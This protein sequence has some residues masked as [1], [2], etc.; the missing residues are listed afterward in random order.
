MLAPAAIS[1]KHS[2][3][4]PSFKPAFLPSKCSVGYSETTAQHHWL[5][6]KFANNIRDRESLTGMVFDARHRQL[7]CPWVDGLTSHRYGVARAMGRS[8]GIPITMGMELNGDDHSLPS[9]IRIMTIP[10]S[11]SARDDPNTHI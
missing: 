7:N 10:A 9:I 6:L 4:F 1:C 5:F 11:A 3:I 2:Q 8:V